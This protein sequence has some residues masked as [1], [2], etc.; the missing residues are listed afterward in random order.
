[1]ILGFGL[2]GRLNWLWVTHTGFL[3]LEPGKR[4]TMRHASLKEDK[5]V[6]MD[7]SK[8]LRSRK[9]SLEGVMFFEFNELEK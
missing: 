5:V 9:K 6:D 8:Y 4:P 1:M 2:V 3:I 7:F